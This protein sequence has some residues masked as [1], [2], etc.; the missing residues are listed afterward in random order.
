MKKY[1]MVTPTLAN[2][3]SAQTAELISVRQHRL[4]H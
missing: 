1:G 4:E 3:I 2:T